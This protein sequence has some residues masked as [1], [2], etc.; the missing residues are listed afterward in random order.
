MIEYTYNKEILIHK[1]TNL[2]I[3]YS[4][5][6]VLKEKI[7]NNQ[8]FFFKSYN[9]ATINKNYFSYLNICFFKF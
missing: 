8:I 6:S 5:L 1:I 7:S 4:P 9:F 2:C 3:K